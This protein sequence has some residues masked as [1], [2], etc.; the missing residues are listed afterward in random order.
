MFKRLGLFF[1]ML[2][3]AL[4]SYSQNLIQDIRGVVIDKDT[5]RPLA[6]ATVSIF[7]D[8]IKIA[9]I[10]DSAGS[11][12]LARVP[13]GRRRVQ[14]SFS[15]YVS[16]ITDNLIVNSAKE[17]EIIIEMEQYFR[18]EAEVVVKA[19]GN[20]KLPVNKM[21]VV[22]ARSFTPE[23]TNRYATSVNDPSRMAMSFPGVQPSRDTR[24]DINI[25][26]NSA[27]G[28]LWRLE[29]IDIPNPNHFA[30]KGSTGGGITI[31][32]SSMLDN[33]DF[34][35]GAFPAEYGDALSGVFDMRFRKGNNEKN[36]YTFKAG[37]LGLDLSA[38]GPIKKGQSSFLFNYRYS[39]LGILNALGFHLT[40]EREDNN[41]QDLSFNLSFPSKD[42]RSVFNVWGIGGLSKEDYAPVEEVADWDEYDDYAIYDFKT[43]MGAAGIGH[44]LQVGK[45]GLLK[46]SLAVM[47]QKI[48]YADDTLNTQKVPF[49]INDELYKNSRVSFAISYNTKLAKSVSWK[50]GLFISRIGY[51]FQQ[52]LYDFETN[53]YNENI[54]DGNGNTMQW[55]PYT[56]FNIK[57]SPKLTFNAGVHVLYLALNKTSSVDPRASLQYRINPHHSIS[58]AAGKHGK[59]L[60]LGSYFYKAPDG[61]LPNLDLDMM[62]SAHFIAAYDWLMKKNWRLHLEAYIQKLTAI[63][64][65]NDESRTFWLLNMLEGYANEALVSSGTGRN[66]GVDITLEKFF[67]KGWFMLTGFSVFNSMYEPLNGVSYNTQYNSRSA[68]T[69]TA[70]KEWKW[71][72]NKTFTV[73][74]KTLYNG[75]MPIT[76]L[77]AGA[78]VNSREPVLDESRPY[79]EIVPAYFR[80][81]T[82]ISLRKDKTT[83]AWILALDIQNLLGIENTDALSRRYDPGTNQWIYKK[84]S[85]FVPVISYQIDF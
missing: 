73:G 27:A 54:I 21:S 37:L 35:S 53:V 10:T 66:R 31:F 61:S 16:S 43:N 67:S 79:S 24:S 29:G 34:S 82:R 46:T 30:R 23:E 4:F 18:Q 5:R 44:S 80:L 74:G 6:G 13:V 41:F 83:T 45:T 20:P 33:S 7:E 85:G 1:W 12:V 17:V 64:I 62:K 39:T 19:P 57:I 65:V 58:F 28:M 71:K 14:C 63:P 60:P 70:G 40:D 78:P 2:P 22:S 38:E 72:K 55:Q 51:E 76:P 32:S 11:F 42:N 68:G 59:T 8:S 26:G 84:S 25:R 50:T 3:A 47:N 75:G 69:L 52:S 36:G 49:T 15:G 48:T 81:D 56:Q 77:L 9:A